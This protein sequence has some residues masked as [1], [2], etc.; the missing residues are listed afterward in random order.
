MRTNILFYKFET[1]AKPGKMIA[2]GIRFETLELDV[3]P[4]LDTTKFKLLCEDH[5]LMSCAASTFPP[6]K[7]PLPRTSP[8]TNAHDHHAVLGPP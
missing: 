3:T 4:A 8:P 1:K 5:P 2:H 7:L 6:S